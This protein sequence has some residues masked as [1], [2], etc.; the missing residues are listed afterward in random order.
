V[1]S[2]IDGTW[3]NGD[4]DRYRVIFDELMHR[5]DEYLVF[6]DLDAY[7]SRTDDIVTYYRDKKA[8]ARSA[9]INIAESGYFS[10]DRTVEEYV[11]DIWHLKKVFGR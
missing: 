2:L 10:S 3:A 5:N 6:A 4:K 7:L 11:R 9:I 8:W 1:N